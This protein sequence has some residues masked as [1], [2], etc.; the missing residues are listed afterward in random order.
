[1]DKIIKTENSIYRIRFENK[2]YFLEKKYGSWYNKKWSVVYK[3][4]NRTLFKKQ[5][6]LYLV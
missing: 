1:M 5:V 4:T 2:T 3:T 6:T